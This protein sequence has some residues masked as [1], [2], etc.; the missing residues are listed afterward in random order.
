MIT[1]IYQDVQIDGHRNVLLEALP[2][3][4]DYFTNEVLT[5]VPRYLALDRWPGMY[6]WPVRL[7]TRPNSQAI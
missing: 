3:F 4:T 1:D 7:L 2:L 5:Q 6:S